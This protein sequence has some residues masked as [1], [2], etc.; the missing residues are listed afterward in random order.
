MGDRTAVIAGWVTRVVTGS[1]R[2]PCA[3]KANTADG[4]EAT[5]HVPIKFALERATQDAVQRRAPHCQHIET[6]LLL[7][8]R[9]QLK[10]FT[11]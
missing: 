11:P 3:D 8:D 6:S 2:L 7:R 9:Y 10:H 4:R 1:V 5:V